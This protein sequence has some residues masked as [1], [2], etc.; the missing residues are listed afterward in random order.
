[1][2]PLT[3]ERLLSVLAAFLQSPR[4]VRTL[5]DGG[6]DSLYNLL[7]VAELLI[8]RGMARH[9]E[10]RERTERITLLR[11]LLQTDLATLSPAAFTKRLGNVRTYLTGIITYG[12]ATWKNGAFR[13]LDVTVGKYR[14]R[15]VADPRGDDP[16]FALRSLDYH[17]W[18]NVSQGFTRGYRSVKYM[19]ANNDLLAQTLVEPEIH[20][21]DLLD[22]I[23]ATGTELPP[24]LTLGV[25]LETG[26]NNMTKIDDFTIVLEKIDVTLDLGGY[27][28]TIPEI[29][30]RASLDSKVYLQP[31]DLARPDTV[32][33]QA[34]LT[35]QD[36]IERDLV[37][38][39]HHA[40]DSGLTPAL[41]ADV[42]AE[43]FP[44]LFHQRVVKPSDT[45]SVPDLPEDL[46]GK[47][48]DKFVELGLQHWEVWLEAKGW[49]V[50]HPHLDAAVEAAMRAHAEK[51][52]KSGKFI[53]E[54]DSIQMFDF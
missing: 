4:S 47:F 51:H 38:V 12:K 22:L 36:R 19:F 23:R 8:H 34:F 33:Q 39:I 17:F 50:T 14:I 2:K 53:Y 20:L 3:F 32:V 48:A 6:F 30:P 42:I 46:P 5:A 52:F 28:F 41:Q 31:K 1:M 13:P 54:T 49:D 16:E 11:V 18:S 37:P 25:S 24:S 45:T 21:G 26:S 44:I 27:S 9:P 43:I 10:L 7:G 35:L 40:I 29:S 15:E